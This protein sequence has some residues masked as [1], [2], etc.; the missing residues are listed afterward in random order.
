[1]KLSQVTKKIETPEIAD[2]NKAWRDAQSI[3]KIAGVA[4]ESS[5]DAKK[6][7]IQGAKTGWTLAVEKL[8]LEALQTENRSLKRQ[9]PNGEDD[10]E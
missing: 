9:V 4:T 5:K 8:T 7:F 1:M 3:L 10:K 2:I 6:Y